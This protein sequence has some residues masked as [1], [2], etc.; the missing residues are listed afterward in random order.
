M[1]NS[2]KNSRNINLHVH[3]FF[4]TAFSCVSGPFFSEP[5]G[6]K[7]CKAYLAIKHC[8]SL[9]LF[10]LHSPHTPLLPSLSLPLAL[11]LPHR[12]PFPLLPC[13]CL[14]L[15]GWP[16]QRGYRALTCLHLPPALADQWGRCAESPSFSAPL[17]SL[18]QLMLPVFST[19]DPRPWQQGQECQEWLAG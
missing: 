1:Q 15:S 10:F 17:F 4:C 18:S 14:F 9:T 12:P 8:P 5:L 13:P 7:L 19:S 3:Y 6:V 11:S 2:I 16:S